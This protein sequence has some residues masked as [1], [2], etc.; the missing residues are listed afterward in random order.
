MKAQAVVVTL[1]YRLGLLDLPQLKTD[2]ALA[3]SGNFATLDQ[4]QALKFVNANIDAFGGDLGNVTVMGE[5]VGAANVWALLVSPLTEGLMHKAIAMSGGLTMS[6]HAD[7]QKY[8]NGLLT[9]LVIADGKA[10]DPASTQV[11]LATRNTLQIATYL[12]AKSLDDLLKASVAIR[13][14]GNAPFRYII[15]DGTVIPT[16]PFEAIAAGNYRHV[17]VLEGNMAEEG[18]LFVPLKPNTFDRFTMQYNFDPGT[19]PTLVEGDLLKPQF[20]PVDM[21]ATG[22][23]AIAAR[24]TTGMFL[25]ANDASMN[26]LARKQ[27][28]QL[29]YYRFDWNQE[30]VP[31][32]NV[33]GATQALDLPFALGNFEGNSFSFVKTGNPNNAAIVTHWDNWPATLVFD[34]SAIQAH[35]FVK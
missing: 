9:A 29:W 23:N 6:A 12:R 20:L 1:N 16:S 7:T 5:S 25:S 11:Y 4:I 10:A 21:P 24:V 18:K 22:W 31:F 30:P 35:I 28:T 15:E 19:A 33:Y 3:D 34:A 17:P 32:N 2:D 13:G 14:P 26:V 27:P 8:A